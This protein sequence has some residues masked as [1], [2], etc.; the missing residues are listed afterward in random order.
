MA[1][2]DDLPVWLILVIIIGVTI[3]IFTMIKLIF[4]CCCCDTGGCG[5]D[6]GELENF[7]T[8]AGSK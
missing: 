8:K 2:L 6:N 1:I 7:Q 4:C 3:G 5:C